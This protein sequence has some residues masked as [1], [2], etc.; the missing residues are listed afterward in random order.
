MISNLHSMTK[1][2]GWL[3]HWMKPYL[4]NHIIISCIANKISIS[5]YW[6]NLSSKSYFNMPSLRI[7]YFSMVHPY[8]QYCSIVWASTYPTSLK[9]IV[10]LQ[11]RIIRIINYNSKYD[12]HTDPI[13][14]DLHGL[15]LNFMLF[16]NYKPASLFYHT[17]LNYYLEFLMICLVL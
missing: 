10:V 9:R 3:R 4:G 11:K 15:Y 2:L 1:L 12:A 6:N 14:K 13:F 5:V 8:L 7:L 16:V 17:G